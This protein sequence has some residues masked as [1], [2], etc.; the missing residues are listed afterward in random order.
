MTQEESECLFKTHCDACGSSDAN[1]VYSDDHTHCFSCGTTARINGGS[2]MREGKVATRNFNPLSGDPMPLKGRGIHLDTCA[3]LGYFWST[4]AK[5]RGMAPEPVQVANV[6]DAS[7]VLV[8]QKIRFKDKEFRSTGRPQ[9]A[10]FG[11]HKFSGGLRL[12]ITEGEMDALT[13]SQIGGNKYP[14]V[15]VPTGAKGAVKVIAKHLDWLDNFKEIVLFFDNDKDGRNAVAEVAN[16][17]P[18]SKVKIASMGQY[19]D[20]NEALMDNNPKAVLDAI[21]NAEAYKPDGL[22]TISDVREKALTPVEMGIPWFLPTL[23]VK[24]YGRRTGELV[25]LGAGTGVGKTD[26]LTQSMEYDAGELGEKVAG[27]LLEQDPV[28]TYKRVAGKRD[29][30]LYHVPDGVDRTEALNKAFDSPSITN[31]TLYDSWG[32]SDWDSIK[33]KINYLVTQGYRL[34]Y[35]DHLT[36]LATGSENRDEKTELERVTAEMAS[37]CKKHDIWMLVVSHLTTPENG[38]HEEGARVK[39][40]HFKGSRAIGFWGHFMFGIERNQQ[41]DDEDEKNTALFRVLKDRFTGQSTGLTIP[42]G[43]D[44][45]TG[46]Q[47]ERA[48][49]DAPTS[50]DGN[51]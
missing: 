28:D 32:V 36:A 27:F 16:I 25:F 37:L 9:D 35:V 33:S 48:D 34:F 46:R 13:V 1:A 17:L 20:A 43:Y 42:I 49:T 24:T 10:L 29:R 41:S 44:A 4:Y 19:K 8:G 11:M 18:A 6:R 5:E 15:S 14:T 40:R 30:V 7:G 50:S 47:F 38:S 31:L 39:I 23:T 21:F 2:N 51:W 22:L 3:H 12:V 26:F 45:E